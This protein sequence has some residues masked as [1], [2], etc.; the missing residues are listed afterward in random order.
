MG[1]GLL[2]RHIFTNAQKQKRLMFYLLT[3][4]TRICFKIQNCEHTN[5][6][7]HFFPYRSYYN[8]VNFLLM[9]LRECCSNAQEMTFY[10][11]RVQGCG[12]RTV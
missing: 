5:S 3:D 4:K 12:V 10:R 7:G 2:F 8:S 1:I 11:I 9:K 6:H